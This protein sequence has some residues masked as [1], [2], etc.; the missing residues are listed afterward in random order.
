[1]KKK[2]RTCMMICILF[3]LILMIFP[4]DMYAESLKADTS[5]IANFEM[6]WTSNAVDGC[7]DYDANDSNKVTITPAEN[8]AK[9][10]GTSITAQVKTEFTQAKIDPGEI[11]IKLPKA[12]FVDR[13]G[14]KVGD[15]SIGF[16]TMGIKV[17]FI[18]RYLMMEIVS[19]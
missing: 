8:K 16:L 3:S 5:S 19:L 12:I 17:V 15:F 10:A 13:T 4:H 11:E 6:K 18:I 1:M 2:L 9:A 7:I 14:Q